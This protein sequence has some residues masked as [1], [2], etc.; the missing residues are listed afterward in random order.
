MVIVGHPNSLCALYKETLV[1]HKGALSLLL[2][3]VYMYLAPKNTPIF[4][5]HMSL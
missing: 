4:T 1:G 5:S 2:Q 3:V